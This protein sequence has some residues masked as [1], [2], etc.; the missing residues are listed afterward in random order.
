MFN[1]PSSIIQ[2]IY[3]FDPTYRNILTKKVFPYLDR[4]RL[5]RIGNTYGLK[6]TIENYM[7]DWKYD[8]CIINNHKITLSKPYGVLAICECNKIQSFNWKY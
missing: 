1:L 6:V 8:N 7:N 5:F 3:S 4:K 2:H